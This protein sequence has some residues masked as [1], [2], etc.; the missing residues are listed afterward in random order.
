MEYIGHVIRPPSEADSLILQITIGCSHN[1]CTFCG[2]YRD[3]N[4]R[5]KSDQEILRDIDFAKKHFSNVRRVFLSDGDALVL[6]TE[7]LLKI[8]KCL[9]DSFKNIQRIGIYASAK[10]IL[11]K[12]AKELKT[13]FENKLTILYIGLESGSNRIL[14][15]VNK[16]NTAEEFID[17]CLRAQEAGMKI[18]LIVLL[19]LGGIKFS[20]EHAIESAKI[21]NK[22][23]PRYLSALTL[24]LLP[25]TEIYEDYCKGK[26][27]L[28]DPTQT[29]KE[30]K[31]LIENLDVEQCIFR[32]NHASNY[33][34]LAGTLSKDKKRLLSTLEYAIK[35]QIIKPDFLRAL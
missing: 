35:N 2:V 12:D 3:V 18:S 20:K 1:K 26:F 30:L 4:F 25:N 11:Q 27:I 19:G 28:P 10:N 17:A 32:S 24:M 23:E 29:L 16:N 33:V 8:L 7:K 34:P 14:K 9:H 6:K 5:I 21:I 22:I 13:L 15:Q 31:L